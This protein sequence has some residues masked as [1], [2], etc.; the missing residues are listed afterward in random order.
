VTAVSGRPKPEICLL[1]G[2]FRWTL[3]PK[4]RYGNSLSRR[5]SNTQPSNWEV[6]TFARVLVPSLEDRR[7]WLSRSSVF[8][9]KVPYSLPAKFN[10]Q[11][12]ALLLLKLIWSILHNCIVV[13]KEGSM[14]SC[15]HKFLEHIVILCFE[16]RYHKQNS[17]IRLKSNMFPNKNSPQFF[18]WLRYCTTVDDIAHMTWTHV[19]MPHPKT[20]ISS[21]WHLLFCFSVLFNTVFRCS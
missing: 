4:E 15:P 17:D 6:G 9:L 3:L 1:P 7:L 8:V 19:Y 13:G 11:M 21:F 18:D 20:L 2:R 5:G 16:R 12:H 14:G 10:K